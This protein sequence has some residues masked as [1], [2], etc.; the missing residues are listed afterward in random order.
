MERHCILRKATATEKTSSMGVSANKGAPR[1]LACR[2]RRYCVLFPQPV[3]L[4][5]VQ[6]FALV[7]AVFSDGV[8]FPLVTTFEAF[9]TGK[10][11]KKSMPHVSRTELRLTTCAKKRDI[12]CRM[13]KCMHQEYYGRS[14]TFHT[15]T[16]VQWQSLLVGPPT[17]KKKI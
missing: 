11:A 13:I 9:S 3:F 16:H 8:S 17:L 5:P 2:F 6:Y 10:A 1:Q 15:V 4:R 14:E 12:D 7:R